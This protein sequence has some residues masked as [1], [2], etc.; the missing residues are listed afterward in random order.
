MLPRARELEGAPLP[1]A[2]VE[3]V[4]RR[5]ALVRRVLA[6]STYVTSANQPALSSWAFVVAAPVVRLA[7][8]FEKMYSPMALKGPQYQ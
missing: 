7:P 2:R 3:V 5:D 6:V 8:C 4:L 1:V